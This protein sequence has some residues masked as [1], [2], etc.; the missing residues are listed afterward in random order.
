MSKLHS[1]GINFIVFVICY[2]LDKQQSYCLCFNEINTSIYE[3]RRHTYQGMLD[4][5]AVLILVIG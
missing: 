3:K 1:D 2:S 5:K 4:S